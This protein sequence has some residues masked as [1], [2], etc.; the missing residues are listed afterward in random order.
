M[1]LEYS[2]YVTISD[3]TKWKEVTT[4]SYTQ[5]H[6][7]LPFNCIEGGCCCLRLTAAIQ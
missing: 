6:I 3:Q 4:V 2:K 5:Q 1:S 7:C